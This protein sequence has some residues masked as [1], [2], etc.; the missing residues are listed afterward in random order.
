MYHRYVVYSFDIKFART[1]LKVNVVYTYVN[2][3]YGPPD[4]KIIRSTIKW[5][6]NNLISYICGGWKCHI[7]ARVF[8][9]A[10]RLD[11]VFFLFCYCFGMRILVDI[12]APKDLFVKTK[13]K[14]LNSTKRSEEFSCEGHKKSLSHGP[15]NCLFTFRLTKC[16]GLRSVSGIEPIVQDVR[17]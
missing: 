10:D 6:K 13:I 9:V 4:T 7:V 1:G 14:K 11:V 3:Q 15:K 12:G 16:F 8:Y 2:S 5:F 17:D